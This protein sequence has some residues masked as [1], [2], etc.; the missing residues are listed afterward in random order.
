MRTGC[1]C[2]G[3]TSAS[4]YPPEP[5]YDYCPGCKRHQNGTCVCATV[6]IEAGRD[7]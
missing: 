7:D 5:G 2:C 4:C 1:C 6:G 3:N